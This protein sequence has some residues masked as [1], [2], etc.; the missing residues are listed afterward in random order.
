MFR[1]ASVL[2]VSKSDDELREIEGIATTP[3]VDRVGD[4][5][6]PEGIRYRIPLPL[7]LHHDAQRPI[8]HAWFQPAT[9]NG[10][11]F[12]ARIPRIDEAGPLRDRVETAW[13]EVK[14]RLLGAV[15]IGFKA[16]ESELIRGGGI[17]YT[18]CEVLELSLCTIPANPDAT[19]TG[20]KSVD[21]VIRQAVAPQI[22]LKN[23]S[24]L[25]GEIERLVRNG[26]RRALDLW[27]SGADVLTLATAREISEGWDKMSESQRAHNT[28]RAGVILRAR[29]ADDRFTLNEMAIKK[30][31]DRVE[32]LEK[33][34][35]E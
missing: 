8:G 3:T 21:A 24:V 23:P 34:N 31:E 12:R 18:K 11:R 32:A 28:W 30:I 14:A 22:D 33:I 17:R 27:W 13:Q 10:I 19:I 35:H 15:S 2:R 7:L 25:R 20:I 5:V 16:V 6:E 9:A 1:A 29:E 26:D 4:I